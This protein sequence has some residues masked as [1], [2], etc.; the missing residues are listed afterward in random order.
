MRKT[1]PTLDMSTQKKKKKKIYFLW[2]LEP[3]ACSFQ[4]GAP[5]NRAVLGSAI[6]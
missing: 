6:L 3:W 1:A 5:A 4:A 2:E